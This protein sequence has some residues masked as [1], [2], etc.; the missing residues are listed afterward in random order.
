MSLWDQA[1]AA[2]KDKDKQNIDF[3]RSDKYAILADILE[4]VQKKKQA[5]IERRLKYKR[6]NGEFVVLYD[7]YEKMVKWVTKFK[8]VGDIAMQYDPGHA[9][10]PWAAA[11][12]F[13]LQVRY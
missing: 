10:L 8:E 6:K 9:A 2:L 7:V 3:Q 13:F 4:E 1:V 5:C 11:V 12:R